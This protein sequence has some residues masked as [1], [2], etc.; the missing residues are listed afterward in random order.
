MLLTGRLP[1]AWEERGK[2]AIIL[3]NRPVRRSLATLCMICFL[4]F[5]GCSGKQS[6]LEAYLKAAYPNR[7]FSLEGRHFIRR[8]DGSLFEAARQDAEEKNRN[9]LGLRFES[10][11]PTLDCACALNYALTMDIGLGGVAESYGWRPRLQVFLDGGWWNM[12][13]GEAELHPQGLAVSLYGSTQHYLY[14]LTSRETLR[15]LPNGRYRLVFD[16]GELYDACCLLEFTLDYPADAGPVTPVGMAAEYPETW[17]WLREN[18]GDFIRTDEEGSFVWRFPGEID[19]TT[20]YIR[21]MAA[22]LEPEA[23]STEE[24][25]ETLYMEFSSL[26]V[27]NG[28]APP[29]ILPAEQDSKKRAWQEGQGIHYEARFRPGLMAAFRVTN[30]SGRTLDFE[31][32]N[33]YDAYRLQVLLDGC[34]WTIFPRSPLGSAGWW[35][36]KEGEDNV[37][38]CQIYSPWTGQRL[39]EGHYRY[40]IEGWDRDSGTPIRLQAEFDLGK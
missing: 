7:S 15:P 30:N 25:D 12:E 8:P 22:P 36:I 37:A 5:P 13:S 6:E 4:L 35:T 2:A 21:D 38:G 18:Y 24:K 11:G 9:T 33:D 26:E 10:V 29:L 31:C 28:F 39:P 27:R 20:V 23:V 19:R 34:W 16:F 14:A 3:R 17:A 1:Q 32:D 40:R